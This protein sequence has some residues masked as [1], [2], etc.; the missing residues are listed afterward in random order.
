MCRNASFSSARR[1][2]RASPRTVSSS[3][4]AAAR[5]RSKALTLERSCARACDSSVADGSSMRGCSPVGCRP[6]AVAARDDGS[7]GA[8]VRRSTVVAGV[9]WLPRSACRRLAIGSVSSLA[10]RPTAGISTVSCRDSLSSVALAGDPSNIIRQNGMRLRA[11]PTG[12]CRVRG[13]G[14]PKVRLLQRNAGRSHAALD[15]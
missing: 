11:A 14:I 7:S 8:G 15:L 2:A 3:A 13:L 1:A 12:A 6:T 10:R 4:R 9:P 5:S